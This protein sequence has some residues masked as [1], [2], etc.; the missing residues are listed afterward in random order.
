M[1][2]ELQIDRISAVRKQLQ[3]LEAELKELREQCKP[4][5]VHQELI[6]N[7]QEGQAWQ[8]KSRS[9]PD[10][11]DSKI[12]KWLEPEWLVDHEYRIHPHN[13]LIQ[14]HKNG[15][16]IQVMESG[17]YWSDADKPTWEEHLKY[18]IKPEFE[19]PIYMQATRCKQVVKFTGLRSGVVVVKGNC[20]LNSNIGETSNCLYAHTDT[21]HW[22]P[23]AFDEERGIAD[24]QLVECWYN[25]HSY[26]RE[27]RFY[28]ALNKRGF[29][30]DGER[31]GCTHD[32]YRPIPYAD[33][34][35]WAIEA[36]KTLED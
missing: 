17:G 22:Q 24:K 14:A 12:G 26:L 29:S 6:D 13:D 16:K 5:H 21:N 8:L 33:Y 2:V 9:T 7:Y 27:L 35:E 32:N 11:C 4:R 19:Y 15:A 36:E 31:D 1:N 28:D 18:R 23:I 25:R 20:L 3:L 30:V 10:W 34:P